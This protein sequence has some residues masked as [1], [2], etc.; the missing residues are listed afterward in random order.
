MSTISMR[1]MLESGV[2]YGHKTSYRNPKMNPYIYGVRNGIHIINLEE[3]LPMFKDA[4][5]VIGRIISHKG[6]VLFVGT[7]HAARD[8]IKEEALRCGMPYVNH[9]WLGGMLT[10][11]KTVRRS[12]NHLFDL[13]K[14]SQDG[15]FDKITKK[16][17]LNITRQMEKLERSLGGIK[18]MG[19][20]PEALFVIDVGHEDIAISEAKRLGIPVLG[21][22]DTNNN[23]DGIDYVIP[24]NDDAIRAIR[25]YAKHAA[26]TVIAAAEAAAVVQPKVNVKESSGSNKADKAEKTDHAAAAQPKVSIKGASSAKKADKVEKKADDSADDAASAG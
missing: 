3:T 16:E 18:H 5:N 9:R 7:K 14:M 17:V 23:P 13:I 4:L 21:I 12:I 8:V 6:K 24:G 26:D 22:V 15:T 1:E 20:I 10:N 11:Y 19:G 2:H 25:F